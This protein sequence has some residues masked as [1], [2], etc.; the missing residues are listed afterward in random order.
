MRDVKIE[1]MARERNVVPFYER[2]DDQRYVVT[3]MSMIT[4]TAIGLEAAFD[5]LCKG[6]VGVRA[7]D[8]STSHPDIDFSESRT[9]IGAFNPDY[10]C[11]PYM[12]RTELRD[13]HMSSQLGYDVGR[14]AFIQSGFEP[15]HFR[16]E[17]PL[18]DPEEVAIIMG[19]C[20]GGLDYADEMSRLL[21]SKG[22]H[23]VPALS[24]LQFLL[25]RV[26]GV[27]SI[28]EGIRG[29]ICAPEAACATGAAA[30]IMLIGLMKDDMAIMGLAGGSDFAVSP[31]GISS[32]ANSRALSTRNNEPQKASRPFDKGSD[33]FVIGGGAGG[34][35]IER[36]DE[37]LERGAT[38]LVEVAGYGWKADAFHETAPSEDGRAAVS[39]MSQALRRAGIGPE[40][41]GYVNAH[42]TSTKKGDSPEAFAIGQV[43]GRDRDDLLVGS[44]KSMTG[45]LLGA[46]GAVE[47]IIAAMAV[48][49]GR[50]PPNVNL[51]NPIVDY[52]NFAPSLAVARKIK[53]AGSN[54]F[55]FDGINTHLLLAQY[56]WM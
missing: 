6:E 9:L 20:V 8:F 24:P 53:I 31:L 44:T 21:R 56:P 32:F 12:D 16:G 50:I 11:S 1:I 30:P 36:L 25:D 17:K 28:K 2:P 54:S 41:V 46:A 4:P 22:P 29:P 3:G 42:A 34:L 40:L 48:I 10:T 55:G 26:P 51:D 13:A 7:V 47:A 38:P 37:A 33:G 14:M 18:I 49:K 5:S 27:I 39:A 52:L 15:G 43:Y 19:T 23:R 45:H 35:I